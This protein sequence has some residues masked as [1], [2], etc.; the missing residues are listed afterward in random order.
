MNVNKV[1]LV[2]RVGSEP[3]MRESGTTTVCNVTLA[4]NSGFG[5]KEKTDWHR[6]TFFGK[7]AETV[8]E[9]VKKGQELY[10]EGRIQYSK[11]TDKE[12]IE[13]YSTDIIANQ[14]QLGQKPKGASESYTKS[15]S[16]VDDP[17]F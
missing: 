15:Q 3:K 6:V 1:M 5:D 13:K 10:V 14:M 17:P 16:P 9:Y 8:G 7:T 11:Y 4:T 12:G 2:G